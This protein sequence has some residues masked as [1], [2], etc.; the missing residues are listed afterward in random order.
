MKKCS[1]CTENKQKEKVRRILN[2]NICENC[3]DKALIVN[4]NT[5]EHVFS[6]FE[7]AQNKVRMMQANFKDGMAHWQDHIS[8]IRAQLFDEQD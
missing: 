8:S 2:Q 6:K 1:L 5:L 4:E 7:S 3:E